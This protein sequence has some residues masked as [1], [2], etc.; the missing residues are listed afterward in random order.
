M[1]PFHPYC[2]LNTVAHSRI[3]EQ[4]LPAISQPKHHHEVLNLA[5][6]SSL[7][8]ITLINMFVWGGCIL[9]SF[10]LL[11]F[12]WNMNNLAVAREG[13]LKGDYRDHPPPPVCG[14]VE[15]SLFAWHQSALK[16]ISALLKT[17]PQP[18]VEWFATMPQFPPRNSRFCS[19]PT[20][21]LD[22]FLQRRD[23]G[24]LDSNAG[25]VTQ[26]RMHRAA[27]HIP[28]DAVLGAWCCRAA[29]VLAKAAIAARHHCS[30]TSV[31]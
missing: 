2:P 27:V 14:W 31:H 6:L 1:L 4:G 16:R 24:M 12:L 25:W 22:S 11:L 28:W 20:V 10:F 9:L 18:S 17:Q 5:S 19:H 30:H 15:Q 3:A 8:L 21:R 26:G 23:V 7:E 29:Q 13:V